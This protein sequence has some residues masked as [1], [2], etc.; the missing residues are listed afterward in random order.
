MVVDRRIPTH[1][2]ILV[3]VSAGSYAI[4]LAGV[5]ALQSAADARLH[6]Q[7]EPIRLAAD[8]AT[9][10]HDALAVRVDQAAQ[11]YEALASRYGSVADGLP[12]M[13]GDLGSLATRAAALADSAASLPTKFALPKVHSSAPRVAA[14]PRTHA[15]TRASGG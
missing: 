10:H 2:A 7:R 6:A 8:S 13:E 1:L 3:G 5:T 11:H 9:A 4:S 12:G 15:T 14:A